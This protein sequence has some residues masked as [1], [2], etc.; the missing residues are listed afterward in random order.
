MLAPCRPTHDFFAWGDGHD[1][2]YDILMGKRI[3]RGELVRTARA[4]GGI[5]GTRGAEQFILVKPACDDLGLGGRCVECASRLRPE[6]FVSFVQAAIGKW[7]AC[8]FVS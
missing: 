6:I 2:P 5:P 4:S 3:A 7:N 1:A 8:S